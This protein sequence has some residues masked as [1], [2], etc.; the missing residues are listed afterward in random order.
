MP[1]KGPK[2]QGDDIAGYVHEVGEKVYEFKPGDRVAAFHE[3][4]ANT[5]LGQIAREKHVIVIR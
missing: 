4:N 1:D 3:Q 2:N 5:L